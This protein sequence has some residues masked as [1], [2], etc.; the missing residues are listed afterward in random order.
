MEFFIIENLNFSLS[1]IFVLELILSILSKGVLFFSKPWNIFET[2]II[3]Y[4]NVVQGMERFDYLSSFSLTYNFGIVALVLRMLKF[5]EKL[6]FLKK[7]FTI[8]NC[9]L[10]EVLTLFALLMI[11]FGIYGILG[12]HFFAYLKPQEAL[13][14]KISNFRNIFS[15]SYILTRILTLDN[16]WEYVVE[17]MRQ[18]EPNFVCN[19]IADYHDYVRFGKNFSLQN[20]KL[21]IFRHQWLRLN[22]CSHLFFNFLCN[23]Q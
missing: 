17:A 9:V 15:T 21:K 11:F 5:V 12:I 22:G 1:L 6:S 7:I 14:D 16:W 20:K 4:S 8:I 19:D 13:D 23:C 10:P 18:Q 2:L 3:L